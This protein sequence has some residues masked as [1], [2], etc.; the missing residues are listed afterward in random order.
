MD[1]KDSFILPLD[2]CWY[3]FPIWFRAPKFWIC[4]LRYVEVTEL[5]NLHLSYRTSKWKYYT[6]WWTL[7]QGYIYNNIN[8]NKYLPK[9]SDESTSHSVPHCFGQAGLTGACSDQDW[10]SL[11]VSHHG[12]HLDLISRALPQVADGEGSGSSRHHVEL[13]ITPLSRK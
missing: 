13:L 7:T 5:S 6:G 11:P 1:T 12:G 4:I 9:T 8:S 10:A 3:H 2:V